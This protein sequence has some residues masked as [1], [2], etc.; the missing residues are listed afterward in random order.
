MRGFA[1]GGGT[2]TWVGP[3]AHHSNINNIKII[4]MHKSI[5]VPIYSSVVWEVK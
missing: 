4:Q 5:I 3:T 1:R 2:H